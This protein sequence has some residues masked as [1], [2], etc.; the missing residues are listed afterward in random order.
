MTSICSKLEANL[1]CYN[2]KA[3]TQRKTNTHFSKATPRLDANVRARSRWYFFGR[4][5]VHVLRV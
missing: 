5:D 1:Q 4:A 3:N 2:T